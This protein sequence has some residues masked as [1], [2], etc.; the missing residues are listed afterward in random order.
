M[1]W[2]QDAYLPASLS[3]CSFILAVQD[4]M[5]H[6]ALL[7]LNCLTNPL[8]LGSYCKVSYQCPQER[9]GVNL[10]TLLTQLT[11]IQALRHKTTAR[12]SGFVQHC[13]ITKECP[14]T[15]LLFLYKTPLFPRLVQVLRICFLWLCLPSS[16]SLLVVT[17]EYHKGWFI[18]QL[19]YK[20][21]VFKSTKSKSP[22]LLRNLLQGTSRQRLWV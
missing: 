20:P 15:F 7:F 19:Q 17:H 10:C 14:E 13:V 9:R 8:K 3:C 16:L 4:A 21:S 6:H 18:G 12:M 2:T 5:T 1:L 11:L 22:C